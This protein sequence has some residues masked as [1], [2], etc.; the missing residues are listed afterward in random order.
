[1]GTTIGSGLRRDASHANPQGNACPSC[2]SQFAYR[3]FLRRRACP[4]CKMTLGFSVPYRLSLAIFTISVFL[5][6]M[7]RAVLAR[8][9]L[10]SWVGPILAV[11]LALIARLFFLLNVRPHLRILGVARCPNCGAALTRPTVRL[12]RFDCPECL[13]QI[14]PVHRSSY[15]WV[16]GGVC[17]A[18]AIGA[19]LLKGFPWSFVVFVVCFYA[20][21]A[22]FFWDIFVMDL[23][24]PLRFERT[25][26]S[27]QL[28]RIEKD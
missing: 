25:Q 26:S 18:L 12:G 5:Y 1:M 23:L 14:Q 2:Q 10:L 6:A 16:R 7:Y 11:I 20:L 3:D 15:W 17:A 9:I 28:I 13:K 22:F 8:G 21:P 24:P 4:T 27:M 19:A